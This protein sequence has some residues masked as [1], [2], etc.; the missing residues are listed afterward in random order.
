M[1][2]KRRDAGCR[3]VMKLCS[4]PLSLVTTMGEFAPT[5]ESLGRMKRCD[6]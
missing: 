1:K 4:D 5:N 2:L 6:G 3:D